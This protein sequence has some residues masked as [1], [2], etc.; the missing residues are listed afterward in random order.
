LFG[1]VSAI[2]GPATPAGTRSGRVQ[3]AGRRR[4]VFE[5]ACLTGALNQTR[6]GIRSRNV[7]HSLVR[8][9]IKCSPLFPS[10]CRIPII[11]RGLGQTRSERSDAS[12]PR[13]P[14]HPQRPLQ[15]RFFLPPVAPTSSASPCAVVRFTALPALSSSRPHGCPFVFLAPVATSP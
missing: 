11:S 9:A 13:G 2:F 1:Q 4:H 8:I 15:P 10:S 14:R 12:S 7:F 6:S 5:L 3:D